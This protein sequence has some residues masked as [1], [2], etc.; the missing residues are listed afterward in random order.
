MIFSARWLVPI[1]S[2]VLEEAAVLVDGRK[3]RDFGSSSQ[4]VSKYPDQSVRH[5]PGAAILPG[6]VNVHSHL[7]L[8]VLRGY[9]EGLGFWDWIR[10]LTRIKYDVLTEEDLTV[11]ALLGAV[12]GLR[13]GITTVADPMDLGVTLRAVLATGLRAF[14]FQEVF[15]PRPEDAVTALENLKHKMH[16]WQDVLSNPASNGIISS[17]AYKLVHQGCNPWH[18]RAERL[19]LG[20]SPHAPYT[21]SGPLFQ[22]AHE[23]ARAEGWRTCI[24]VAESREESEFLEMGQG[25]IMESWKQRG[26]SWSLPGCS[27]LQYL[28]QLGVIDETTLLVHCVRFTDQDYGTL[29]ERK[30]AVAYCPKSNWKLRHGFMNLKRVIGCNVPV[31]LGSDSVASNNTMDFFEEMRMAFFSPSWMDEPSK[32]PGPRVDTFRPEEILRMAT[33]GGAEALGLSSQIGSVEQGKEAD[34]I[35]VDLSGAHNLPVYSPIN[36]LVLSARAD[37]VKLTIVGGEILFDQNSTLSLDEEV[38]SD[39]VETV[40]YK[41]LNAPS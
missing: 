8:T 7:E 16:R 1:T 22:L 10:N 21:V 25:P 17:A 5:F 19:S 37:D 39:H 13:A 4:I 15:S 23:Y 12:E 14:L 30:P 2:P 27:P 31:G 20:V 11:S 26:I 34:L 38:L 40:R 6:F 33:L 35:V 3:I 41:L 9:L 24:H 29:T 36:A 32:S 28:E 18:Q